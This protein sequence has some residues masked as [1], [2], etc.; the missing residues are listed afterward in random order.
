MYPRGLVIEGDNLVGENR[1]QS[2]IQSPEEFSESIKTL[3]ERNIHIVFVGNSQASVEVKQHAILSYRQDNICWTSNASYTE[4][5]VE[6]LAKRSIAYSRD[7]QS[8]GEALG[9][10]YFDI[11]PDHFDEDIN[12]TMD[13]ILELL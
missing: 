5:Q 13:R 8:W 4:Q 1:S 2:T 9:V 7:L 11:R 10:P 3:H 6:D 12:I